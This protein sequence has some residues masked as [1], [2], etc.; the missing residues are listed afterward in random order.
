[1]GAVHSLEICKISNMLISLLKKHT[2]PHNI[3]VVTV[4]Q[5]WSEGTHLQKCTYTDNVLCNECI[6]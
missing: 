1:M 3:H 5:P 2:T 6:M 4:E